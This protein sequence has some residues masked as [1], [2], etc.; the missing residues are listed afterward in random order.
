MNDLIAKFKEEFVGMNFVSQVKPGEYPAY[1]QAYDKNENFHYELIQ[2]ER[3]GD[4]FLEFHVERSHYWEY[5][6]EVNQL[7]QALKLYGRDIASTTRYSSQIWRC[8][9]PVKKPQDLMCDAA[10]LKKAVSEGLLRNGGECATITEHSSQVE[11]TQIGILDLIKWNLKMPP[12]Q[13]EYCWDADNVRRMFDDLQDWRKNHYGLKYH[14]GSV[15]LKEKDS[16]EFNGYEIFDGQQRLTTFAL[17]LKETL[18]ET[19]PLLNE[20]VPYSN[21]SRKCLLS[22]WGELKERPREDLLQWA[23]QWVD[24]SIVKIA[25]GAPAD[26]PFRFFNHVN[27]SGVRLTDY[28]LLKS[29]HL[30]FVGG[31]VSQEAA[32]RWHELELAMDGTAPLT[33]RLLHQTLY[34]LRKWAI[35][36]SWAFPFDAANTE[37]RL[38]FQH[39]R[40]T[41]A[42][43][44]GIMA[45][46]RPMEFDSLVTGGMAFF[47]F[48]SR[49]RAAFEAFS[50][51]PAIKA[52]DVCLSCHSRGVLW[53]GIRA[54]SFLFYLRFGTAYLG[55]AVCLIACHV[56]E[57]RNETRV[58][59]AHLSKRTKFREICDLLR[60]A[61]DEGQFLAALEFIRTNYKRD[62]SGPAKEY[63]W[64]SLE[65]LQ[66]ELGNV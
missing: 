10:L 19:V 40:A 36:E 29:H 13:R 20:E 65:K 50:T 49:Q 26:L 35:G 53:S 38:L 66:E 3:G 16:C 23:K 6:N 1:F 31:D 42:T 27:S 30:R 12:V 17:W 25:K 11:I 8:R 22:V 61:T 64:N 39:F 33:D 18:A 9:R 21:R 63:Y 52:L 62:R 5:E 4:I 2:R 24:V 57:I 45:F 51:E 34:R 55:R 59:G 48:V 47:D 60:R 28:E 54:L 15:I 43:P 32:K 58:T 37:E 14:I 46:P 7:C 44:S 56:S 41:S